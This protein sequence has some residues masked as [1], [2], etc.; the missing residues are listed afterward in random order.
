VGSL[1]LRIIFVDLRIELVIIERTACA[2]RINYS[3]FKF[4]LNLFW[5]RVRLFDGSASNTT[6]G[7]CEEGEAEVNGGLPFE[8]KV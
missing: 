3:S 7:S 8:I 5:K 1:P 6:S 4:A 2:E